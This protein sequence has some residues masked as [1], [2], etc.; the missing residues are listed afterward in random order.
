[1]EFPQSVRTLLWEYDDRGGTA[2]VG[3]ERA[4][5]ERVM[6]RGCW[7]DMR[8][9][10]SAFDHDPLRSYLSERGRRALPPRELRFWCTVCQVPPAQADGWVAEARRQERA[11]RG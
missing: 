8:W 9:L 1:M 10:L 3:W 5:V 6:A 4:A 11:W 7:D 2:G